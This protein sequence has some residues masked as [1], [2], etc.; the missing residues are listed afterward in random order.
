MA[1]NFSNKNYSN[2][3]IFIKLNTAQNIKRPIASVAEKSCYPRGRRWN[4]EHGT[5]RIFSVIV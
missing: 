4:R 2:S 5:Y 1:V 3:H